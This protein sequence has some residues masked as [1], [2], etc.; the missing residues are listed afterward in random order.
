[1]WGLTPSTSYAFAAKARLGGVESAF[2]P[3]AYAVTSTGGD[4]DGD[5][6]VDVV[7]LLYMV[8]SWGRT[9]GQTGYDTRSDFN[10]DS[11]VDVV[12]LLILVE[13]WPK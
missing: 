4:I 1:M 5:G 11:S 13:F 7:D 3:A 10:G 2:S 9:R 6:F 12:D 8:D